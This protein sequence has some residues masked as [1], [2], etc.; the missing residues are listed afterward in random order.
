M[1]SIADYIDI[2]N[3][4]SPTISFDGELMAYLSDESGFNQVWIKP[5]AGGAAWRLTATDETVGAIAFNPKNRD[6]I[7]TLDYGGDER[8]QLWLCPEAAGQPVALTED[9]NTVHVWGCW[10]QD[11]KRIA[12]AANSRSRTD[13]DI[14]VMDVATRQSRCVL[15]G[16]GW[17]QPLAF[18]P[19]GKAILV[20]D[21]SRSMNDQDLL[22]LNLT[23][24][25][26]RVLLPHDGKAKY[27]APK[28]KK[29]RSGFFLLTDQGREFLGLAF[30][31]LERRSLQWV[32]TPEN[33]I[34]A[35]A[36]S[37]DQARLAYVANVEG[38]NEVIIRECS[39]GAEIRVEGNPPGTIS[40]V[41][42][43]PDAG[44]IVFPLDGA[45]SPPDIWNWKLDS[46]RAVP[47]TSSSRAGVD[48]SA[49]VEPKVVEIESFDGR[50][51]PLFLYE[52]K[53]DAPKGGYPVIVVV[54]GGPEAQWTSIFRADLQYLLSQGIMVVAPNVR[55]STGYGK[56]YRDLD[57]TVLRMDSVADLKAV[58]DW[59]ADLP[60]VD[61][62][63]LAVYGRSYGG[64]MVL[65]ALTEYPD[66]WKVGIE[67]YGIANFHTMLETTGPWRRHLRAVEYGDPII[68]KE[69]LERFSPI[70]KSSLI[71]APLLIAHGFE[72]PRVPPGESEMVY[73]CL[74]GRGHP[75][76]YVR[77]PHEGH[78]FARIENRHTVFEAVASFLERHL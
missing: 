77:I 29:D 57:D 52:P 39:T 61:A 44:G 47:V 26:A 72:D 14:Y 78:G 62:A 23:T 58:R 45:T 43:Y 10:D 6:L 56:T 68:D 12:Y 15:E 41:A 34:E 16:V 30:L 32:V 27:L 64:F 33:D 48:L 31:D 37:S 69:A 35:L 19:D 2:R 18:Y 13:M 36:L 60:Q 40:S 49:L 54:H 50:M 71:K 70:H 11:G 42:W 59:V 65:S 21:S 9:P 20:Q 3:A 5:V 55:G 1:P 67:F 28:F 73:S 22:E 46:D 17:R 51:V 76:E 24:G 4:K 25:D 38:W 66:D 53:G 8:H 63:R 7:F 75:V 74:H